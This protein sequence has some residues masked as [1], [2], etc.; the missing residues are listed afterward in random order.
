MEAI[1]ILSLSWKPTTPDQIGTGPCADLNIAGLKV[2]V[3][4]V[5]N[6]I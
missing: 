3:T 5:T 4:A 6:A 2:A 1:G